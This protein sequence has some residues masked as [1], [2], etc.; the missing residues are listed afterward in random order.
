MISAVSLLLYTLWHPVVNALVQVH[1]FIAP[2]V[3]E[4]SGVANWL[5]M[6]WISVGAMSLQLL[7]GGK[8]P[9][10]PRVAGLLLPCPSTGRP[11][12]Q[13]SCIGVPRAV[14]EFNFVSASGY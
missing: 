1:P 14:G 9:H 12:F 3:K 11:A 5:T 7:L 6:C 4:L 13:R 2:H 10:L 8:L